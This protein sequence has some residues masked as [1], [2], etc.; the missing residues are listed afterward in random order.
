M[1]ILCYSCFPVCVVVVHGPE[2]VAAQRASSGAA[3]PVDEQQSVQSD[4]APWP[5]NNTA[6]LSNGTSRDS[7]ALNSSSDVAVVAGVSFFLTLSLSRMET[8]RK[9]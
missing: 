2:P 7:A 8:F 5:G 4:E 3:T 1:W 9:Y 6:D